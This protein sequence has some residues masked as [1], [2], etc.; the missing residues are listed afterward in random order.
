MAKDQP[1]LQ[2]RI[3]IEDLELVQNML[4]NREELESLNITVQPH[5]FMQEQ[6]ITGAKVYYLRNVIHNCQSPILQVALKN[7]DRLKCTKYNAD[8]TVI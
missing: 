5:N 6:P 1:N 3:V 2:G 7:F 4:S 8:T